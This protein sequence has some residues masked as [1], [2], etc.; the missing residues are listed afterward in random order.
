MPDEVKPGG[1]YPTEAAQ[2]L[3]VALALPPDIMRS[4][5]EVQKNLQRC[6]ADA[7]W[8]EPHNIHITLKFLGGVGT[9]KA[10]DIPRALTQALSRMSGF[11]MALSHIGAFP[12]LSSPRVVWAGFEDPEGRFGKLAESAEGALC[13]LGFEKETRP[14]VPHATLARLRSAVNR[15]ALHEKI[16][17]IN[18]G[19]RPMTVRVEEITLFA[20]KLTPRGPVYSALWKL[21]LAAAGAEKRG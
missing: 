4:L 19:F 14:A 5:E 16:D 9:D 11:E 13:G 3:F 12:S 21:K 1:R 2:R 20:S 7:K 15:A 8:V 6:G 18:R 17:G 10:Q